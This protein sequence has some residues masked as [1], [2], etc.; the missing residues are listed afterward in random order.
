MRASRLIARVHGQRAAWRWRVSTVALL[1][2]LG[3]TSALV[4]RVLV[5]HATCAEHGESVHVAASSAPVAP[6]P[7][8]ERGPGAEQSL[9]AGAAL[10]EADQHEHCAVADPR[11][12]TPRLSPMEA[13]QAL[14]PRAH[15]LPAIDAARAAVV[16]PYVIAPKTSPPRAAS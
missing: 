8:S 9:L 2:L 12:T 1:C 11:S 15:A 6:A 10:D 4:H 5:Q 14:E 3:Q 16:A 7:G 13:H